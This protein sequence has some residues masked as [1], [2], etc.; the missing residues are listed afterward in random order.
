[1]TCIPAGASVGYS[2]AFLRL[3]SHHYSYDAWH[4][5]DAMP[6]PSQLTLILTAPTHGGMARLSWSEWLVTHRDGRK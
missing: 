2:S 6:L 5:Y 3:L 4:V 1:M